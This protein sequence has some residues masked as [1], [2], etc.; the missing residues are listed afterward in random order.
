MRKI[1]LTT[2]LVLPLGAGFGFAQTSTPVP[3]DQ[4]GAGEVAEAVDQGAA[5]TAETAGDAAEAATDAVAPAGSDAE[6]AGDEMEAEGDEAAAAADAVDSGAAA[7]GSMTTTGTTTTETTSTETTTATDPATGTTVTTTSPAGA[8]TTVTTDS[9][10]TTATT[11]AAVVASG[12]DVVVR[13]QAPNELR[14]DWITGA[15]VESPT[16]ENIGS[17]NDLIMDETG[18]ITAAIVGV[19]GFLGIGEKQVAIDWANLKIDFDGQRLSTDLS[20]EAADAA[21]GYVFRERTAAPAAT[22]M[23]G[24]VTDPAATTPGAPLGADPAVMPETSGEPVTLEADPA[25]APASN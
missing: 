25:A 23:T 5:A 21:P 15:T 24:T 11:D 3:A 17:I 19:G 16:G 8:D 1:L 7:T 4:N 18:Q 13:D 6:Q 12:A 22:P 10:T 20:R 14:V 9:A 2:A